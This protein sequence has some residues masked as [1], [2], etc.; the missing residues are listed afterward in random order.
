MPWPCLLDRRPQ[1]CRHERSCP[2]GT[3]VSKRKHGGVKG[4]E[5]S[6]T[7]MS[8]SQRESR[9]PSIPLTD[10]DDFPHEK[11]DWQGRFILIGGGIL[12]ALFLVWAFKVIP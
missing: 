5:R 9:S 4:E 7:G 1:E 8:L 10:E 2:G 6:K 11:V 3:T 12:I